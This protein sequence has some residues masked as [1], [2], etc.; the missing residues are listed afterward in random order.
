MEYIAV[1]LDDEK[2]KAIGEVI[3]N[4]TARKILK[5]LAKKN[6][7]E[8]E[9]AKELNL[10][11]STVSYNIKKLLECKLIEV[12]GFYYSEK[13]NKVN[14]YRLAKKVVLITPKSSF[15]KLKNVLLTALTVFACSFAIKLGFKKPFLAERKV[16]LA[17]PES[18]QLAS[19]NYFALF[20]IAG[21]FLALI[22]Y[23]LLSRRK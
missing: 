11:L 10:P 13:G 5:L 8:S 15:V 9:I 2:A 1:S 14:V 6:A 17:I 12:N 22:V 3:S 16:A 19:S 20:F 21:A 23:L 18:S 4:E 7:T